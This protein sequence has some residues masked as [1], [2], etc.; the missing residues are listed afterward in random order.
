MGS[1]WSNKNLYCD[2]LEEFARIVRPQWG[3]AVMMTEDYKTMQ[4]VS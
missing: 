4:T 2:L 3:V 1:R